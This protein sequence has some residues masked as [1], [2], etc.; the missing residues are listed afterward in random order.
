MMKT[1]MEYKP[2]VKLAME[3]GLDQNMGGQVRERDA[4]FPCASAAI[5]PKTDAFACGAA[6]RDLHQ[7]AD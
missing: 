2:A 5:L 3:A 4:A 7:G 1:A 6:V